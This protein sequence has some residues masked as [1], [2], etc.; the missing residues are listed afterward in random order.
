MGLGTGMEFQCLVQTHPSI[1][2][3]LCIDEH[4]VPYV[5]MIDTFMKTVEK[6]L[7]KPP[8]EIPGPNRSPLGIGAACTTPHPTSP[9]PMGVGAHPAPPACL[10]TR[11]PATRGP[12][13]LA[14]H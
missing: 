13:P 9:N 14:P 6:E 3:P 12:L 5:D 11:M 10:L 8:V 7:D 4:N 1:T 2:R